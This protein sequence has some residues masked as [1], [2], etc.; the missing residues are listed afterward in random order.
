M[1]I[2]GNNI[3]VTHM[4]NIAIMS[5]IFFLLSLRYAQHTDDGIERKRGL[6]VWFRQLI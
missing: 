6:P 5:A 2:D 4:G 3:S 1:A